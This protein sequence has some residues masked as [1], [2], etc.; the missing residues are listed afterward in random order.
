MSEK[1]SFPL[2]FDFLHHVGAAAAGLGYAL[3]NLFNAYQS[4][5]L[6][7]KEIGWGAPE[8]LREFEST[9]SKELAVHLSSPFDAVRKMALAR[10]TLLENRPQPALDESDANVPSVDP[11]L[12]DLRILLDDVLASPGRSRRVATDRLGPVRTDSK[13]IEGAP[14]GRETPSPW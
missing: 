10:D 6:D 5:I 3:A 12:A 13:G 14:I 4:T 8:A 7:Y 1:P 2:A 9:S 11:S